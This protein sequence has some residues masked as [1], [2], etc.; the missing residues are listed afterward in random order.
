MKGKTKPTEVF[1]VVGE[2]DAGVVAQELGWLVDYEE[3]VEAISERAF[4]EAGRAK[5]R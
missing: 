1:T 2:K 5:V 4:G 3:A